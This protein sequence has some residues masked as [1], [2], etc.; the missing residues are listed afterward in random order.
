MKA[1]G[2]NVEDKAIK[3]VAKAADGSMR[4]ALSLLD[5]CLAFYLGKDKF[6]FRPVNRLDKATS[7]LMAIAKSTLMHKRLMDILH[8]PDFERGYAALCEGIIEQERFTIDAPIDRMEGD[9]V[10]RCVCESG[11]PSVTRGQVIARF[12]QTNRTLVSLQ[13]ETGRTHQIRVHMAYLGHPILGDTV[14]GAKKAVP[15]LTGQCLHAVGL[16]FIHP[17]T[18]DLVSLTCPLP[19]EFTAM[20]RK[21]D[22]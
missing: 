22:R 1:E 8:T 13:L 12:P 17:R 6:I 10:R 18:K 4:D 3:Y 7:G 16:Q 20:L 11:K 19:E 14:Y 5:Q 15:G 2:L 9:S 21:I